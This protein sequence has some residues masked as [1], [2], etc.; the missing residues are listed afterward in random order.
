MA[1]LLAISNASIEDYEKLTAAIDNSS[2]AFAKLADGSVVPLSQALADG[3]EVMET[4]SGAAEAMS[5]IMLDNIPGQITLIKSQI[6]GLAISYGEILEPKIR[7]AL[8]AVSEFIKKLSDMSTSEKEQIIKIAAIVAAI[9]PAL[10]IVGKIVSS[11]GSLVIVGGKLVGGIGK[12]MTFVS[13]LS[14]AGGGLSAVFTALGGPIGIAVAAIAALAA[15]FA[16]LYT[17]NEQFR[18]S[19]QQI[20]ETLKTNLAGTLETIKPA[21]ENLKNAFDKLMTT[22]EPVFE[23]IVQF[24]AALVTGFANA[25]GPM[26]EVI[27]NVI[28]MI[29]NI[30]Q[31]FIAL[32]QGDFDGF[33]TYMYEAFQNFVN[34]FNALIQAQIAFVIG[35]FQAFGVNLQAVFQQMWTAVQTTTATVLNTIK[36]TIQNIWNGIKTW[37]TTTLT[38]IQT[39]FEE[40]F[41]NIKNAV[42]ERIEKVK[43]TIIEGIEAAVD[44]IKSLPEK[45]YNWGADMVQNLIDG[46][47]SKID[48]VK[49]KVQELAQA[50]SSYIHFSEPDVGPLSNFHTF[51]PDMMNMIVAGINQGIPRVTQAM[52]GLAQSMI[53]QAGG[54]FGMVGNSTNTFNINVYG[55]QGQNVS[56]LADVI[57]QRITENVMRR[58]VAFG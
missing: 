34:G 21:L 15:G 53:P 25:A 23:F 5:K 50:I 33:F 36:T 41:D 30:I 31:A 28:E 7:K 6:E 44:Y 35:F 24:L 39:K 3:S 29:T 16:Y 52:D 17:T 47:Q 58:G 12:L 26:I 14:S 55:A 18:T 49:A 37:I 1:G 27:T 40:I 20:G 54:Q 8:T 42:E 48:A 11:I 57:E 9:G 22:L 46:I 13:G 4:Y 19:V 10:L 2:Q 32:A 51:M 43:T 38:A 56:E 45:F